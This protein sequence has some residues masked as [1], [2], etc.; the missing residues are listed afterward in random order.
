MWSCICTDRVSFHTPPLAAL[1][2]RPVCCR[3]EHA[4]RASAARNS[5]AAILLNFGC[6]MVT[7]PTRGYEE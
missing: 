4:D 6:S 5:C 2:S 3:P 7:L 1:L